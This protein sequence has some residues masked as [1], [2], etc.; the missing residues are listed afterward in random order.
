VE[1][2]YSLRVATHALGSTYSYARHLVSM[3]YEA[4]SGKHTVSSEFLGGTIVGQAP[5][6]DRFVLGS[7]STLR[8][9]DRY[10]MDP[11]GGS[12]LFHNEL[13]YGYRVADGTVEWFYDAGSLW[14]SDRA[15]I[16]RHSVGVGY[17]QGIF[18]LAVA[19]PVREGR[20]EPV[21][22][23]GMNY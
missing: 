11:L 20:I 5:F 14:Q 1:G 16:L 21:F 7:S 23:A 9:W 22:M 8:G 6:F 4:K 17:K 12:R 13:T 15:A 2:N 19:F 18:V 10:E 3:R